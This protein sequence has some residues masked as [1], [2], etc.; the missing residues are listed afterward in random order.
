MG[1][2]SPIYGEW[3]PPQRR[4]VTD[5]YKEFCRYLDFLFETRP[6]HVFYPVSDAQQFTVH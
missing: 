1:I 2:L 3:R 5:S 6:A 4:V